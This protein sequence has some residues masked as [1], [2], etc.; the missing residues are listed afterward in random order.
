MH[1]IHVSVDSNCMDAMAMV[2]TDIYR[3]V[4]RSNRLLMSCVCMHV[5]DCHCVQFIRMYSELS[6]H[7][8]LVLPFLKLL[9]L[10]IP[11]DHVCMVI[12]V[13]YVS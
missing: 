7:Q 2:S 9:I 5:C 10:C 11:F 12:Y 1:D 4:R 8:S 13:L 6:N 3:N